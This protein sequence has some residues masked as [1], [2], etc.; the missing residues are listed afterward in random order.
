ML[1]TPDGIV[2]EIASDIQASLN[3]LKLDAISDLS[4]TQ[5]ENAESSMFVT[6]KGIVTDVNP[7]QSLN[8]ELPMLVTL[9]GI[10]T[11]VNPTHPENA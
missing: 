6:L 9:E 7:L 11:D 5:L 1:V 10:D 3:P 2:T 8:A 4:P